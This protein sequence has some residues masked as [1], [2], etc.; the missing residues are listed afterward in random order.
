MSKII[1][2]HFE[3]S[4]VPTTGLNVTM[5]IYD[6]ST[7]TIV[8]TGAMTDVGNGGYTFNFEDYQVDKSYQFIANSNSSETDSRYSYGSNESY[9]PDIADA[10]WSE[11]ASGY[12]NLDTFG[13]KL[14]F[15]KSMES[16]RWKIESNQMI[17]YDEDGDELQRFNL[18]DASGNPTNDDAYERDP[19]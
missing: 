15:I 4:S 1:L 18:K 6:L 12:T 10:V 7:N 9:R 3:T 16:G 14:N 5:S 11:P 19:V 2:S 17:F 8:I 13:G